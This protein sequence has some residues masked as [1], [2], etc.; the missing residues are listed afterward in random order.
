MF[1]P[2]NPS[3]RLATGV[4]LFSASLWGLSW[5]PLKWF[6]AQGLSGPVVSLLSY[7]LVGLCALPFIWRD[8]GAWRSQWVFVLALALVGGWANT[9]FVNALM[10]GDVVRVMFL[11]Y[12]SPVWSVLGGW[13]FLKERIPP[14]RWAA[15][16]AAI[17]GLWMVLGGP[18]V[19][20]LSLSFV[21]FLALS[22]GFAFAANNILARAAQAVPMRTKTLAVFAGCGAISLVT[23][24]ALGHSV[25][26]MGALVWFGILAYGFGWL[27]LATATWQF[28]VTHLE[29]SRAGVILLAE[30][31][32]AVLTALW[33][34][35]ETLTPLGWAGGT[36]IA[37]AALVE[38]LG[39][40]PAPTTKPAL[41]H[42]AT[43]GG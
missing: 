10:M 30:L 20:S 36:L 3:D 40:T 2:S 21:D 16:V 17:V 24:G 28:G 34:G 23:T 35:G 18:G 26:T 19:V 29:S 39:G 38:A 11:F 41:A 32:V 9:S 13:L 42:P 7:G 1:L 4:L 25:P 8:R 15:V 33:F 12:L 27:L 6:I 43:T 37:V 5:V 22:A 31:V 14:L